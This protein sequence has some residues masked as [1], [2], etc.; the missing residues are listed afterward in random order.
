[1]HNNSSY[2]YDYYFNIA[3]VSYVTACVV[4]VSF[5]GTAGTNG[6]RIKAHL[7][8]WIKNNIYLIQKQKGQIWQN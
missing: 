1:M 4:L 8:M 6:C 5:T 2:S 3:N 7:L